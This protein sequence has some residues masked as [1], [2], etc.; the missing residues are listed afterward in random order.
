MPPCG[1]QRTIEMT[2]RQIDR[3]LISAVAEA[4]GVSIPARR[5]ARN[6]TRTSADTAARQPVRT[7]EHA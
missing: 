6:G 3:L 5:P 4:L 7:L 1:K 2:K